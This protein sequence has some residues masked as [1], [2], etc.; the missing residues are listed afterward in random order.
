MPA[1][2]VVIVQPVLDSQIRERGKAGVQ[3][4]VLKRYPRRCSVHTSHN[5]LLRSGQQVHGSESAGIST[6]L[7]I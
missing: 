3:A 5:T 4:D 2:I 6:Y 7:D 1:V